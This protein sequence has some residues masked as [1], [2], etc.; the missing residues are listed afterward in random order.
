[1][2]R[3]SVEVTPVVDELRD[4]TDLWCEARI[5][6]GT[7]PEVC[8]RTVADGRL[9][10]A[11]R[12]PGV[13][14]FVARLDGVAVGYVVTTDNPFGLTATPEATIEQL[15]VTPSARRHGVA[16]QLLG[17]V[18]SAAER[19]G[20]EHV[21][22]N[23]PTT[24]REANRFFARLGFGSVVTRRVVPTAL[25]RR[26]IAPASAETGLEL[27]RRRR[28]LRRRAFVPSRPA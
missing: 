25:L 3:R 8:S 9:G 11:L 28:S 19:A 5:D 2:G 16:K 24:S 10:A 22:S 6:A 23:V 13:Q 20:C 15:W 12:R 17:A 18:L 26:R 1:M 27:T 4:V 7:S 21:V 14:A